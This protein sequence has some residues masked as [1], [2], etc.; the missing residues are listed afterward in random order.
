MYNERAA[1]AFSSFQAVLRNKNDD[2]NSAL[3]FLRKMIEWQRVWKTVSEYLPLFEGLAALLASD[4]PT[5]VIK[6]GLE[7]VKVIGWHDTLCI[8]VCYAFALSS[9]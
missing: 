9:W 3:H 2:A 7:L 1:L 4:A 8:A 5:P 6:S